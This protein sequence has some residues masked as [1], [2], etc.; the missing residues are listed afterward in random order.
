[1]TYQLARS[2]VS[3]AMGVLPGTMI[4]CM[5]RRRGPSP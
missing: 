2:V 3:E 5:L 1:M 4:A